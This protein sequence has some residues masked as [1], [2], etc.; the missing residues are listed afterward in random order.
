M[1]K[2]AKALFAVG[3]SICVLAPAA[4][5]A[6]QLADIKAR[7]KLICGVLGNV[8]PLGFQDSK[9]RELVGFDV[10][11]CNAIAAQM[12]LPLEL[13]TL[14]VEARIPE[15]SLGRID[16][17]SAGVAYN[18]ERAEQVSF[19]MSPYQVPTRVMVKSDS[20]FAK[21]SDLA[22]KKITTPKASTSEIAV[23][24]SIPDASILTFQDV[25]AS[26]LAL[27]QD[28]VQAFALTETSG[29]RFVN[30][31]NGAIKWLE[32]PISWEQIALGVRK[33]EPQLLTAVN[34]ALG[35]LEKAGKIEAIWS[36]WFGES[37]DYKIR[38][39]KKLTPIQN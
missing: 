32:E 24:R 15:L 25:P 36:K 37:T 33:N 21:V 10:D 31:S 34:E 26:F 3:L 2:R 27:Q 22:G 35:E 7:G 18:K 14:S 4:T 19:T 16:I 9:T 30:Q 39:E 12:K 20:G 5:H 13:K 38:R 29:A 28:K 6:D 8:P 1:N 17:L 11:L 23:R